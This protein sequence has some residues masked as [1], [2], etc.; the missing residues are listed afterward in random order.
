MFDSLWYGQSGWLVDFYTTFALQ[1]LV[2]FLGASVTTVYMRWRM[3]GTMTVLFA[4]I[5]LLL[6]FV[7]VATFSESWPAVFEWFA[8]IGLVGVFTVI[9]GLAAASAVG[10]YLVIR[11]ATPR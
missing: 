4:S 1:L 8:S 9:L 5:A 11:R 7:A 6:A 3:R 2:L 10:G